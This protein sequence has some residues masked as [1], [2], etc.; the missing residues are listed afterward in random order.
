MMV[1]D[2]RSKYRQPELPHGCTRETERCPKVTDPA[3]GNLYVPPCC[4][5]HIRDLF[6]TVLDAF[7]K[8]EIYYWLDYGTLLGATRDGNFIPH[9]DDADFSILSVEQDDARYA[10]RREAESRGFILKE[11]FNGAGVQLYLSEVN[12]LHVDI[13][14]WVDDVGIMRRKSYVQGTDDNKGKDFPKPW[15]S[16]RSEIVMDG[17]TCYAPADPV[18]MCEWRYGPTW[19]KPQR[20]WLFNNTPNPNA[21]K[22]Y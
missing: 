4:R 11:A 1:R 13:F 15:I 20:I 10:I 14:F 9:D 3:T 8:D 2:D 16:E 22:Q 18:Q 12:R 17:R 5:Q 21:K 7:D 19:K 6:N